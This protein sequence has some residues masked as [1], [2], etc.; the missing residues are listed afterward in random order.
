ARARLLRHGHPV[1]AL[2][3]DVADEAAVEAAFAEAV[4]G[5]G[6]VDACFANAGVS[7]RRHP[8][9]FWEM[10]TAEWRRVLAVNLDGAF[11]T[12]RA[13]PG[14]ARRVRGQRGPPGGGRQPVPRR[15]HLRRGRPVLGVL[16]ETS[17]HPPTPL[18]AHRGKGG[19]WCGA[20]Q[21]SYFVFVRRGAKK[22][23]RG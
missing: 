21:R 9:P 12:L 3:V 1:L 4:A 8:A 14:R 19:F 13:A 11:Y 22:W 18:P 5:L 20:A 2:R 17:R 16:I 10:P 15:P 6:R 23:G 7:G